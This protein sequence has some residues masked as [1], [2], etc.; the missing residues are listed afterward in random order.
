MSTPPIWLFDLDSSLADFE[1]SLITTLVQTASPEELEAY[2]DFRGLF[3]PNK[4][5]EWYKMRKKL[6]KCQPGFWEHLP[7]IEFGMELYELAGALAYNRVIL[8]KAPFSN[9]EAWT[10]KVKWCRKHVPDA[11]VI[12]GDDKAFKGQVHG[13]ILYDDY[14]PYVKLWLSEH[15]DGKALMLDSAQSQGFEHPRV[16]RCHRAPLA[17][18]LNAIRDFLGGEK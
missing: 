4:A 8:T 3:W 17:G 1:A 9:P 16:L 14:P 10:E 5:P 7:V 15:P 12:I 18:Q 11:K 2:G 13:A 6:I